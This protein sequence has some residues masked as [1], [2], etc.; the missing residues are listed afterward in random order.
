M[1]LSKEFYGFGETLRE[2]ASRVIVGFS[3]HL[4]ESSIFGRFTRRVLKHTPPNIAALAFNRI[5]MQSVNPSF[6]GEPELG[7]IA[8]FTQ[9]GIIR[10]TIFS[11][12]MAEKLGLSACVSFDSQKELDWSQLREMAREE[13][14]RVIM[15]YIES[16]NKGRLMMDVAKDVTQTKPIIVLKAGKSE[17]GSRAVLSHTGQ[18]AGSNEIC[19]A[20]FRQSGMLQ[21][22]SLEDMLDY[23]K[24]LCYYKGAEGSKVGIVSNGGGLGIVC[25]DSCVQMGLAIPQL[26]YQNQHLLRERLVFSSGVSNPIDLS[27]VATA[28]CYRTALQLLF[29]TRAVDVVLLIVTPTPLLKMEDLAETIVEFVRAEVMPMIVCASGN[30]KFVE[31]LRRLTRSCLPIY[32]QPGKGRRRSILVGLLRQYLWPCQEEVALVLAG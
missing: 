20:A 17:A 18:L 15:L 1:K 12:L 32:C 9:S 22:S 7:H 24:A 26:S 30:S 25:T 10:R 3:I 14:T 21:V 19:K 11:M 8:L 16:I 27:A 23:S 29:G 5:G 31:N 6:L 13:N 4:L 28:S 2:H